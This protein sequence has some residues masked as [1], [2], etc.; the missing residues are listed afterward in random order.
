MVKDLERSS[1]GL[2]LGSAL[3]FPWGDLR[4]PH[5]F[6]IRVA[7]NQTDLPGI[8]QTEVYNIMLQQPTQWY[9]YKWIF[10]TNADY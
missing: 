8:F 6:S 4:K 9:K 2:F 3:E 7:S 10:Y 5:R 1:Y